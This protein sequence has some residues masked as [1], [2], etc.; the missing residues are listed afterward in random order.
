MTSLVHSFQRHLRLCAY[1]VLCLSQSTVNAIMQG[2]QG[3]LWFGTN[4]TD[5]DRLSPPAGHSLPL[6]DIHK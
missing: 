6:Q 5:R 1:L 3:F 2:G 4:G